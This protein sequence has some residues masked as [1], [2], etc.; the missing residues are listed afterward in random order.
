[1]RVIFPLFA[2][3]LSLFG[4]DSYGIQVPAGFVLQV[5]DPTDG[6]IAFPKDWFYTSEGT[7]S[8]WVWTFAHENPN[9]NPYENG[10]RIQ[11]IYPATKWTQNSP[12]GFVRSLFESKKRTCKVIEECPVVDCGEYFRQCLE[13]IEPIKQDAVEKSF[14]I[15]YTAIRFKNDDVIAI[16]T[17]GVLDSEWEKYRNISKV[18]SQF[19]LFGK[20]YNENTSR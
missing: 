15:I 2:M 5:L 14:H 1:M 10:L 9:T 4:Q 20:K 17:F 19:I 12:E 8:G 7:K 16:C 18:M 13:V 6:R 3:T 11:L